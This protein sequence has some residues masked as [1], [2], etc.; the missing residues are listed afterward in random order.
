[1]GNLELRTDLD[2]LF[3]PNDELLALYFIQGLAADP[4][5]QQVNYEVEHRILLAGTDTSIARFPLQPMNFPAVQ[6]PIPLAQVSQIEPGADYE[7]EIHI[8][9]LVNNNEMTHKVP[10][11]TRE[12]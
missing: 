9:D 10:F 4:T 7:I 1:V 12:G 6:Q 3:D 8:K 2:N 5:T 11:S